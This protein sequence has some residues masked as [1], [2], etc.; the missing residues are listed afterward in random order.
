MDEQCPLL[1]KPKGILGRYSLE[2][3]LL[4]YRTT[5]PFVD[6]KDLHANKS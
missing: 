2:F 5:L 4:P 3:K 6:A 1:Q